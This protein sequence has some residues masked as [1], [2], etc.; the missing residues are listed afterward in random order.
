MPHRQNTILVLLCTVVLHCTASDASSCDEAQKQPMTAV[1]IGGTGAIGRELVRE[2]VQSS[3]YGK[4]KVLVRKSRDEGFY[5]L[6]ADE[7]AAKMEQQVVNF[8]DLKEEDFTGYGYGFSA[9]G[10]TRK[11]AGSAEEFKRIDYGYN[12]KAAEL[13]KKGGVKH[14]QLVSSQGSNANSWLLYPKTKGEIE[15]FLKG[16]SF[17]KLTIWRPGLLAGRPQGRS[18]EGL[19]NTLTPNFFRI[20]V[21]T[22]ARA[23]LY[24]TTQPQSTAPTAIIE[25]SGIKSYVEEVGGKD[26]LFDESY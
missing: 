2:L 4:V 17:E 13:M 19:A 16:L 22:V 12:V 20:H 3:D 24:D 8:D 15:N 14:M 11:D 26:A 9:F 1:V 7:A 5:G 25:N 18:F 21:R 10:T 23:M 6:T